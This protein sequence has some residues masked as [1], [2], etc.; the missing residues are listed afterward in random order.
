MAALGLLKEDDFLDI[1]FRFHSGVT[2]T[3]GG[4]LPGVLVT[5]GDD[6]DGGVLPPLVDG[7][8]G[9]GDPQ[10]PASSTGCSPS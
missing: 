3:L 6:G 7:E 1:L 4:L 9:S 5:L 10:A 8:E 2:T